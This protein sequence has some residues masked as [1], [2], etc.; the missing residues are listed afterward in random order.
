MFKVKKLKISGFKSFAFTCEFEI[1]D[2][3]TGIV[4]PNGCGKSNIFEAI[5]WVMGESSSKSLRSNS[6]DEVIF[7]GTDK[8]PA[9]NFA[10]VSLELEATKKNDDYST[11]NEEK[12]LIS[13]SIERGMGS[14]YKINNKEV[15]A[16]DVQVM[17][18]DSGSGS[19]SSSIISQGNI[20]QIINYKPIDRKVIL[21]DAAGIS[22][23]QSRRRESELKL[24]A[25]E[26]NLERLSDSLNNLET[27]QK[28]L[29]RQARQAEQYQHITDKIKQVE[30]IILWEDW[31]ILD[32]EFVQAKKKFDEIKNQLD[33][34]LKKDTETDGIKLI[35]EKK[36][37]SF[38][39]LIS[40][41]NKKLQV[42]INN[43]NNLFSEKESLKN[44]K[45]EI[46]SYLETISKDKSLEEKRLQEFEKNILIIIKKIENFSD[47]ELAKDQ[48]KNEKTNEFQLQEKLKESESILANEKQ[49]LLGEEFKLDNL[50]ESK[51]YLL[52]KKNELEDQIKKTKSDH[53]E[54]SKSLSNKSLKDLD[55]Q[56]KKI[57]ERI[58]NLKKKSDVI[59]LKKNNLL[60]KISRYSLESNIISKDLTKDISE[61]NTLKN[62]IKDINLSPDSIFNLLKIEKGYENAV[63]S[64]LKEELNANLDNSK[65]RW[66]Q[67][68]IEELPDIDNKL[69][70]HVTA[71][72][73]LNPILSQIMVV[74]NDTEGFKKQKQLKFGQ[75]IVS[76]EGSLWR[77]DGF[78]AE[79]LEENKKWFHYKVRISELEIKI[80]KLE[81]NL[82]KITSAK[83]KLDKSNKSISEE[84]QRNNSEIENSYKNLSINAQKFSENKEKNAATLN[85]IERLNEKVIFLNQERNSIQD[86]LDKVIDA[87][88]VNDEQQK[89]KP[90][91]NEDF[92]QS[93][94]DEIKK[95][96][97]DKRKK[98]NE[99][100]EKILADEINYKY[101]QTDLQQNKKRKV[102]S[103]KQ[104]EN[105][106]LREEKYFKQQQEIDI[107]PKNLDKKILIIENSII[108]LEKEISDNQKKN[109]I[110][111]QNL[112]KIADEIKKQFNYKE[113]LKENF[114]R[115]EE[116]IIHIKEKKKDLNDIIFQRF[117]C[118]P[119]EIKEKMNIKNSE[120]IDNDNLK[121][122]L[123]KLSFQREQMGPVNLRADIEEKEISEE[124]NSLEL[125]KN[126]LLLAIKKLRVAINQINEQGKKKLINAF[127]LVNKNFSEIFEKL[128]D[129]GKASLELVNSDD[130]LQTGLEIFAKPPGK[131]LTNINLLSGGEKTLTAVSLIFSIFLINPSP[132]CVLDEVDAALD[133]VNVEK[134]CK[135]LD[136]VKKKTKTKFLIVTHHKITMTM[137]DKVYGVTMGQKGISDIVSV[138]FDTNL[139]KEVI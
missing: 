22:G 12:I 101:L 68:E 56:K 124:L 43:K 89:N 66:V 33:M 1:S 18:S 139:L 119:E 4:G 77:W 34:L 2:G 51:D 96:I 17:F 131:K 63:Y 30:S 80:K 110:N 48:L 58:S 129:G 6:M 13:R 72:K 95:Q 109:E 92:T 16:K 41:L 31:K 10:E 104:L 57:E 40:E 100:N 54:I 133:D 69:A 137:V 70:N 134:F 135:I 15:R 98:I 55:I 8:I 35:E 46:Q 108:D 23:L 44:R 27:Q 49:L 118:Q 67:L 25:T 91:G 26:N 116:N 115:T 128:F 111:R 82:N 32:S 52:N 79:N 123:E 105:F 97:F 88:K 3:V 132:L 106:K 74:N 28:S 87:Q 120:K 71:P 76:K 117:K 73:S 9:K 85:N 19:R 42:K 29:K 20:D 99:L 21:E 130:P 11:Q 36:L 113:N 127:E 138:N 102:E 125:E 61:I 24:N 50:K 75:I 83:D 121:K 64:S 90:K 112:Q 65:K 103:L 39:Q 62:L 126:D 7:N 59:Q 93:L 38:N 78:V 114:I 107:F 122:S 45:I 94:V 53:L 81:N 47:I 86:E 14:F 5:R 37:D 60:E 136:E 84:I